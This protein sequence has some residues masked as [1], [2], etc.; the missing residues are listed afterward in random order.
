MFDSIIF[1]VFESAI[2][3][4]HYHNSTRNLFEEGYRC[5]N[6]TQSKLILTAFYFTENKNLNKAF[7]INGKSKYLQLKIKLLKL[8]LFEKK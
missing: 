7:R 4:F 1:Q 2:V 5:F 6:C 3:T 8:L